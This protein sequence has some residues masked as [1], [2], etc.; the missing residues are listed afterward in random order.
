MPKTDKERLLTLELEKTQM[1]KDIQEIKENQEKMCNK[2]DTNQEQILK[3]FDKLEG[4]FASKWVEWTVKGII[5]IIGVAVF[6]AMV[7]QVLIK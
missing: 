6:G 2:M 5:W 1:A 4:K 7:S 3:M